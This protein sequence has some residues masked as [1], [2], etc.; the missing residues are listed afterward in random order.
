MATTHDFIREATMRTT[1]CT[2]AMLVIS[3]SA[4]AEVPPG[5]DSI[6]GAFERMLAHKPVALDS[7]QPAGGPG[8]A[9]VER[10]VNSAASQEFTS[11]ESGFVHMLV[12]SREEP[13]PLVVHGEPDPLATTI[14]AALLV[15]RARQQQLAGAAIDW[16]AP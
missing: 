7:Q 15:Q 9:F 10:W 13:R 8:E 11:L 1:L 4:H 2:L 16:T 3:A 6:N 14:A 5:P 12:R